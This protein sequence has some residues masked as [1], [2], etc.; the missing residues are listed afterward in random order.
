[1]KSHQFRTQCKEISTANG[2][3][4]SHRLLY[5]NIFSQAD[6][7]IH[8]HQENYVQYNVNTY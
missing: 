8:N 7:D 4:T 5:I 2:K 1:M 3:Q 6:L